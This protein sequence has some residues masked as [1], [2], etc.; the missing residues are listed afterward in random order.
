MFIVAIF[1]QNFC[2][3]EERMEDQNQWPQRRLCFD[4]WWQKRKIERKS[5]V[6]QWSFTVLWAQMEIILVCRKERKVVEAA[7]LR[8]VQW[9]HTQET[10][11]AGLLCKSDQQNYLN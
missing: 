8:D 11:F 2:K 6:A 5:K 3:I 7:W 10:G 9:P 1:F 4:N